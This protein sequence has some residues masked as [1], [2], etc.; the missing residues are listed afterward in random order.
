MALD[1][2]PRSDMR[3]DWIAMLVG[4]L[5]APCE[6]SFLSHRSASPQWT[7]FDVQFFRSTGRTLHTRICAPRDG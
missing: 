3:R 4:T 5:W 1:P 7:V 6:E 2:V